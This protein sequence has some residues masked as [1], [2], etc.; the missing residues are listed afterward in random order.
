MILEESQKVIEE[1]IL[2]IQSRATVLFEVNY[3][4]SVL[5]M[6]LSFASFVKSNPDVRFCRPSFNTDF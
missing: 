2:F 4:I 1:S 5:D 3:K 6:L